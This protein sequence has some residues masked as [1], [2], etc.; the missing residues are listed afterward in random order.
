MLPRLRR[1]QLAVANPCS[2]NWDA[3]AGG[4]RQR[5]CDV[6]K[7]S[8]HD[9]SV[10]TRRQAIDLLDSNAGKIC[11][12]ID[13]D[14]LGNQIFAKERNAFERLIQI[15]V[16]GA[17]AVASAAAAPSCEVNVRIVDPIGTVIP[18]AKLRIA[19]ASATEGVSYATSNF[20]GEFSGSF[21]SG[22]YALQVD[23]PGFVSYRHEL[24]CKAS[25]IVSV[26][27]PLQVGSFMGEVVEVTTGRSAVVEKPSL[28]FRRLY[29]ALFG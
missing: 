27:V 10:L 20:E 23:A 15:S 25:E 18:G 14:Q 28:F 5:F 17:S 1:R 29:R 16:L 4:G 24:T 3:M 6:C 19:K 22:T 9:L 12:R 21:D 8:V 13:Y 2:E 11:G 26:E 7:R